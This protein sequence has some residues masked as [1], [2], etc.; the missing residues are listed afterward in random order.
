MDEI[1][2][3]SDADRDASIAYMSRHF[4][5]LLCECEVTDD[6]GN[7]KRGVDVFSGFL[8]DL[9]GHRFFGDCNPRTK[10]SPLLRHNLLEALTFCCV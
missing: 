10:F 2:G 6:N 5:A 9:H 3:L 1:E 8:L 4:V 7:K